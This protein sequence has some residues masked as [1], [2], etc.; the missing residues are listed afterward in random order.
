[1]FPIKILRDKGVIKSAK[2]DKNGVLNELLSFFQVS[3]VESWDNYWKGQVLAYRKSSVYESKIGAIATWLR[4]GEIQSDLQE[5]KT[6]NKRA[7][8]R[9]LPAIKSCST[10]ENP[11]IFLEKV[12]EILNESGVAF[13]LLPEIPGCLP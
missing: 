10:I 4:L 6:F 11:N 9:S 7:L 8:L 3:S 1:M 2:S 5:L 12:R 13:I